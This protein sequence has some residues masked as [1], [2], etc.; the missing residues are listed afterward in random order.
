MDTS[1]IFPKEMLAAITLVGG[2]AADGGARTGARC[3]VG[4]P[5]PCSVAITALSGRGPIPSCW[6]RSPEGRPELALF[7]LSVCF[8]LSQ[9]WHAFPRAG[10]C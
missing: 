9:R 7:P 1:H 4:L 2:R 5:P 10:E 6:S 8:P 3:E